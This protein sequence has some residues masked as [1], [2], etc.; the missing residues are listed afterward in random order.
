MICIVVNGETISFLVDTGAAMSVINCKDMSKPPPMSTE[1][2]RMV[3]A[4]GVH[5][6]ECL[7]MPLP[8]EFCDKTLTHKFLYFE[9]C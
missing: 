4:L 5:M 9:C 3:G 2:L 8:V 6:R 1:T 7:S